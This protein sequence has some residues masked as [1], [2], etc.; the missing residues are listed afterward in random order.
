[1]ARRVTDLD[2]FS[3]EEIWRPYQTKAGFSERRLEKPPLDL[4]GTAAVL[5]KDSEWSRAVLDRAR[6][7]KFYFPS[8]VQH[9]LVDLIRSL[10]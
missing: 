8:Y 5:A 7:C 6:A 4:D 9:P 10:R 3:L 1:M 2:K